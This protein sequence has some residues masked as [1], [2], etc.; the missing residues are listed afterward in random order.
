MHSPSLCFLTCSS[1]SS[2]TTI[3]ARTS[4]SLRWA[5]HVAAALSYLSQRSCAALGIVSLRQALLPCHPL[6]PRAICSGAA[7]ISVVVGSPRHLRGQPIPVCAPRSA[8]SLSLASSP[9]LASSSSAYRYTTTMA[10]VMA[11]GG[12]SA[13][14]AWLMARRHA[15]AGRRSTFAEISEAL[16][17]L[18]VSI[19]EDPKVLKKKYRELVKKNHPDAGGEEATMARVTVAYE[20]LNELTNREREAFKLQKKMSRTDS[21]TASAASRRYRPGPP[22]GFGYAAPN[23]PFQAH[24]ANMY[25]QYYQQDANNAYQQAHGKGQQGYWS[26]FQKR[27]GFSGF[28]ESPFSSSSPFSM[29]GQAQRARFMPSGSLLIKGLVVYLFLSTMFLFAYRSYRDWRHDDGW[30][31]SESLARHEQMQEI[32]RIRQEMNE[33][34]RAMLLRDGDDASVALYGN[35]QYLRESPEARALELARQRRIQMAQEQLGAAGSLPELRGWPNIGEDKGRIIKRAQDPPGVVFFEPRREDNLRRQI[36]NQRRGS[37]FV[38]TGGNGSPP[39][40]MSEA[41]HG[42]SLSD[43]ATSSLPTR[44]VTVPLPPETN[45]SSIVMRPVASEEEAQVVMRGIFG[46][47]RKMAS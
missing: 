26:H 27:S 4:Y 45:V 12:S 2:A 31:M 17:V 1:S 25:G 16:D 44:G 24:S 32:H 3:P 42:V 6:L 47:L 19:D 34:G 21:G 23:G 46:S 15:S 33:R 30:R 39:P 18:G 38:R 9:S 41:G 14:V 29:H 22:G 40:Q 43:T 7:T 5:S 13:P 20:R 8:P 35:R 10:A 37:G 28:T 36:E 11:S